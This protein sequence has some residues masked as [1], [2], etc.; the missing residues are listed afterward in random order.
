[1]QAMSLKANDIAG[2]A[3]YPKR[4]YPPLGGHRRSFRRCHLIS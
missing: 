4:T 1:M 3:I 2:S